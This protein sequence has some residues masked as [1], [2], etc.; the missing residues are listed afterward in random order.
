MKFNTTDW[1]IIKERYDRLLS[2][3]LSTQNAPQWLVEWSELEAQ[4]KEDAGNAASRSHENTAD[5]VAESNNL[6]YVREILPKMLIVNDKMVERLLSVEYEP[7]TE[8]QPMMRH[9]AVGQRLFREENVALQTE[10][11]LLINE[12]R[13]RTGGMTIEW[14]GE[15]LTLDQAELLLLKEE[16]G[17]REG[18]WRM[19]HDAWLAERE[20]LN[21]LYL[22]M[23]ALRRQIA[24]QA[25]F[26]NHRAYAWLDRGRYD[27]EPK[28]AFV[29]HE[30]IEQEVVPVAQRI[31]EKRRQALGVEGLRPWDLDV[32]P[33]DLPPLRPFNPERIEELEEGCARIFDAIDPVLGEQFDL[34]RDGYLDLESRPNKAPG[35]YCRAL[36]LSKRSYIFMNAV[37][38]HRNVQTL[39]HEGGHAFHNQHANHLPLIWMRRGPMEMNEVASMAMELLA[40]PYLEKEKGGFYSQR[41][42]NRARIEHLEKIVLFLPYMA[43][44]DAFQHWVY[45]DAPQDVSAEMLSKKWGE[46]WERFM[47]GQ[48]W[49]GLEASK[50]TGWHRKR[51]IFIYP[52][53]YI[54]YGLAQ[55]GAL[56]LWRNA[57]ANQT[58]A[59]KAYR[60]ALS[61]G[62]TRRLPELYESAG[63]RFA[64][65]APTLRELMALVEEQLEALYLA[66]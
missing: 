61:L 31:Y 39:L 32:E 65:D 16:R 38:K 14:E 46:L 21:Q 6:H 36:H 49:T 44:V 51:H 12:Y 1:N 48:D 37:G 35:G 55:V 50:Q 5:I 28:D 27:Y 25:E 10:V 62:G 8:Q 41:D 53:Y 18:A 57:L 11:N 4:I 22:D 24:E 26:E 7:P 33:S 3:P 47:V 56:Q 13:K 19:I 23:L 20:P 30:A 17:Q 43:V 63:I 66:V 9:F 52:F 59:L 54:E 29:F 34:L 45:A 60:Y 58:E 15:R 40:Q 64:F 2:M 42:A